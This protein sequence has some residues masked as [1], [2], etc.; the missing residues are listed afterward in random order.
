MK[1]GFYFHFIGKD[2]FI[3]TEQ[4]KRTKKLALEF[5][6]KIQ[7]H[8]NMFYNVG[9]EEIAYVQKAM[10]PATFEIKTIKNGNFT[11]LS[12]YEINGDGFSYGCDACVDPMEECV[13][14]K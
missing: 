7:N 1:H 11:G 2:M 4:T 13:F 6:N 3:E 9:E 14:V 10:Q 5:I 8:M 12:Y